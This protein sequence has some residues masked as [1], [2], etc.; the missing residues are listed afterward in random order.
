VIATR[1]LTLFSSSALDSLQRFKLNIASSV[2]TQQNS[3]LASLGTDQILDLFNVSA[4]DAPPVVAK[5]RPV[6]Q[7]ALLEGLGDMQ[8]EGECTFTLLKSLQPRAEADTP[9]FRPYRPRSRLLGVPSLAQRLI[10]SVANTLVARSS[11]FV[12]TH[13]SFVLL[14]CCCSYTEF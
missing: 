1:A 6:G 11:L 4:E 5:D 7:K 12:A 9:V 2:V 14:P 3:D 13:T 8:D 10:F